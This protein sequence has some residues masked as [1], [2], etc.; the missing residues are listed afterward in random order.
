[1]KT[2]YELLIGRKPN[3]SYFW[4]LGCKCNIYKKRQHIG[5]FQKHCDIGFLLG[6]SLKSKAYRVFNNATGLVE[7]TYDVEFDESNGSQGAHENC[8]DVGNEPLREAMKNM[9]I[10]DV[11]PKEED[12]STVPQVGSDEQAC[13]DA[14]DDSPLPREDTH[15]SQD[16]IEAQAQDFDTPQAP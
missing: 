1:L 13:Q 7:E 11:K 10:G 3:I 15:V 9:P 8:D 14:V 6:Y 5:K 2:P 12:S 16:Q 4:E